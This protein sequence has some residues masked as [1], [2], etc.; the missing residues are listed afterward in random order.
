MS[1]VIIDS[2][3]SPINVVFFGFDLGS[4]D[5]TAYWRYDGE[6]FEKISKEEYDRLVEND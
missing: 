4:D 6:Q 5:H 3:L 2:Q 1:E